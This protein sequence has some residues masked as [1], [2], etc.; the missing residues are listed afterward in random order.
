MSDEVAV[1]LAGAEASAR[2]PVAPPSSAE[3]GAWL[4]NAWLVMLVSLA[5]RRR[6]LWHPGAVAG[7]GCHAMT[8]VQASMPRKPSEN[9]TQVAIRIPDAWLKRCD[10]LIPWLSRPG[11]GTTRT[12][13]IRAAFAVGLDRLEEE[14]RAAVEALGRLPP[15]TSTAKARILGR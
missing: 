13:A 12:D 5:M 8:M 7:V 14:Q 2:F 10:K 11:M 6:V 9:A 15:T 1:R 4:A 3:A